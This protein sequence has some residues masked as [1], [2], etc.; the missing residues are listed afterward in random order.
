MPHLII[1]N[2]RKGDLKW[3][4]VNLKTKQVELSNGNVCKTE[5][6]IIPN[7]NWY[8]P[9]LDIPTFNL[10]NTRIICRYQTHHELFTCLNKIY[11][12][13]LHSSKPDNLTILFKHSGISN[14]TEEFIFISPH[15]DKS[16]VKAINLNQFSELITNLTKEKFVFSNQISIDSIISLGKLPETVNANQ[17][18]QCS[19]DLRDIPTL[20]ETLTS[21]ELRYIQYQIGF[22]VYARD[23]IPKDSLL[24]LYN[25]KK[26]NEIHSKEY[27]FNERDAYNLLINARQHGNLARFINHAKR[28]YKD[29][30]FKCANVRS[31]YE[32]FYG[33]G[34]IAIYAKRDI[35]PGEQLLIDYGKVTRQWQ[36]KFY[37][38]MQNQIYNSDKQKVTPSKQDNRI[39]AIISNFNNPNWIKFSLR[40]I[41]VLLALLLIL[42]M[43]NLST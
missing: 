39:Q 18:C 4:R 1:P 17:I 6:I 30:S 15:R 7:R 22:G 33:L 41:I 13:F 36:K 5:D 29:K 35:F 26:Q 2:Q 21:F 28:S 20:S 43:T 11:P 8:H 3:A 16:A 38:S 42:N 19:I 31:I 32:N 23:H 37:F 25:G 34:L 40:L 24:F 10:P 12:T 9:I 27:R 14:L